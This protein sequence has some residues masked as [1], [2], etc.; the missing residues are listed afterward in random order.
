MIPH[1]DRLFTASNLTGG[2]T[3][4][5]FALN[6]ARDLTHVPVVASFTGG[7][8]TL[9]LEG[10]NGPLDDWVAVDTFTA[11]KTILAVRMNRYRVIT[12]VNGSTLSATISIGVP[13]KPVS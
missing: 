5:E 9:Q 1:T 10:R 8:G 3:G 13:V 12:T 2:A 11:D 6:T 7:T 4:A